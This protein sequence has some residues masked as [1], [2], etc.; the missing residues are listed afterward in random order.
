MN[1]A[2]FDLTGRRALVT[3]ASSGIGREIARDLA[4]AGLRV[5]AT[6][7]RVERLDALRAELEGHEVHGLAC[8]LRDVSAIEGLFAQVRER[9]GGVDVL[10]NNAGLGHA[11]PL[12]RGDAEAW[13]EAFASHPEI[14]ERPAGEGRERRHGRWSAQEQSGVAAA[15]DDVRARLAARNRDYRERFG[16]VFLVCATGRRPEEMLAMLERRLAH[17]PED[18]L[19]IAAD[20]Q[21]RILGLRL[22]KLLEAS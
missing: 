7:R 2:A 8:D 17:A 6:A 3:G 14:G 18:E 9:L 21:R 20:E 22:V 10:V 12:T 4:R 5:V 13:R 16:F 11:A 19:R 15:A 1:D